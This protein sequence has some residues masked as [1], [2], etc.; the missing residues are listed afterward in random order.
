M[1]LAE[2]DNKYLELVRDSGTPV[3]AIGAKEDTIL[4]LEN[5]ADAFVNIPPG[6]EELVARVHAV[7]RRKMWAL[8]IKNYGSRK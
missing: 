5:G 1:Q 7:F 2:K 3:I 8:E 4:A 6:H